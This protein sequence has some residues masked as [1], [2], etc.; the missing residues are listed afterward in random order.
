MAPALPTLVRHLT[1]RRVN[2]APP[3]AID[4]LEV[5][6]AHSPL[7]PDTGAGKTARVNAPHHCGLRQPHQS[8]DLPHREPL[9]VGFGGRDGTRLMTRHGVRAVLLTWVPACGCSASSPHSRRDAKSRGTC[10][11]TRRSANSWL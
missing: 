10:W 6:G 2:A 5:V 1:R 7:G 4:T 8:R 9:V 11:S 3:C